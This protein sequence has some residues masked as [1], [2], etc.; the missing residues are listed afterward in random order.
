MAPLS[1]HLPIYWTTRYKNFFCKSYFYL[2][3]GRSCLRR[4]N[5]FKKITSFCFTVQWKA[6][7]P[8][9]LEKISQNCLLCTCTSFL[10]PVLCCCVNVV[11]GAHVVYWVVLGCLFEVCVV[12]GSLV[13]NTSGKCL[14]SHTSSNGSCFSKNF[15]IQSSQN[16]MGVAQSTDQNA[17]RVTLLSTANISSFLLAHCTAEYWPSLQN[18]FSFL[19]FPISNPIS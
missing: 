15:I 11:Y 19:L 1:I 4:V 6:W 12:V 13:S 9:L 3:K 18:V 5:L 16:F 2:P 8:Y 7:R 14:D 10:L 17:F